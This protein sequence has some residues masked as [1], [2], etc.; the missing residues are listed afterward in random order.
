[1]NVGFIGLGV[2]GR[3]M[4]R[5]LVAAGYATGLFVRNPSGIADDLDL[6]SLPRYD[7]PRDLAQHSDV[8][9]TVLPD[10][11]DVEAV[12]LGP[13]GLLSGMRNGSVYVDMSTI[14]PEVSQKIAAEFAKV[15]CSALDAPVSGGQA[16]AQSG[17]LSVMVGGEVETLEAVRPILERLGSRIVH[18]GSAGAGQ[19]AKAC[20]QI[21]VAGTIAVVAEA[22]VL[23]E[24]V[25]VDAAKVR[26]ALIGGFADSRILSVHGE[27]ML[28]RAFTPGFR[29]KLQAKDLR[30]GLELARTHQRRLSVSATVQELLDYM[31]AHDGGDLDHSALYLAAA[32]S[33]G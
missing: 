1:M 13:E 6:V 30:I 12:A 16:G 20:N 10:T 19:V 18:V 31:L 22:L 28:K 33:E 21:V 17:T 32:A 26:E 15:G 27:R 29:I 23:A 25:G 3:P 7:S 8:V 2:M 24:S 9:I 5:N 4:L 11:P 14:D